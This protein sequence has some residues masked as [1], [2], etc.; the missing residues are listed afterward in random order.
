M[1]GV[2]VERGAARVISFVSFVNLGPTSSQAESV[3]L[4]VTRSWQAEP[5]ITSHAKL[6][7]PVDAIE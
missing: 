1:R 5:E 4:V 3:R 2:A 7:I 6:T